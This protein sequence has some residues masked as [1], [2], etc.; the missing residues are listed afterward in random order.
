MPDSKQ[1][2]VRRLLTRQIRASESEV[3]AVV[4]RI[5]TLLTRE[6]DRIIALVRRGGIEADETLQ[7]I[8][9]LQGL[10]ASLEQAGL[11]E[12][13]ERLRRAFGIEL[14]NVIEQLELETRVPRERL[15]F[16]GLDLEGLEVLANASIEQSMQTLQAHI[17]DARL[18]LAGQIITGA[19]INIDQFAGVATPRAMA[20]M[21]TEL[22][23]SL[24]AF[25]RA[26]HANKAE[27][28]GF[29]F[30]IYAGPDDKKTRD[31]CDHLLDGSSNPDFNIPGSETGAYSAKQIASMD[32][33]QGLDVRIY[34]GGFNC[35]HRWLVAE[36]LDD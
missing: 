12:Q 27:D 1:Q 34:G 2:R 22:R 18:Q 23:T 33:L 10:E 14:E 3:D 8:G 13:V 20:N 5:E 32:N 4:N 28:L 30:F 11:T 31:F 21:K 36:V 25:N 29:K 19:E 6:L 17:A 16:S 35:R 24:S 7:I 9:V 15:I 26:A